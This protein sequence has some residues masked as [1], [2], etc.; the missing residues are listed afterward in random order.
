[1]RKFQYIVL[2]VAITTFVNCRPPLTFETYDNPLESSRF[3]A[4]NIFDG[5]LIAAGGYSGTHY[6]YGHKVW[7]SSDGVTWREVGTLPEE[8]V[9]AKLEVFDN[10]LWLIGGFEVY[11][12]DYASEMLKSADGI[13]WERE[14]FPEG[15]S[16]VLNSY[17][18]RDRLFITTHHDT[19][20]ETRLYAREEGGNW[21]RVTS[22]RTM[23][24]YTRTAELAGKLYGFTDG[25]L[26][27]DGSVAYRN[28]IYS[29]T[30]GINWRRE[31]TP[32]VYISPRSLYSAAVYRRKIWLVGG[33]DGRDTF[34]NDVWSFNELEGWKRY[35]PRSKPPFSGL[36]FHHSLAY[37]D[38]LWLFLGYERFLGSPKNYNLEN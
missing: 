7:R 14:A 1:M 10:T 12:V 2:G 18:F 21:E 19:L 31:P 37:G 26:N 35:T 36:R 15:A 20:R 11:D 24:I 25:K 3:A 9:D 16:R 17:V 28:E 8:R 13:T 29:T 5:D 38:K 30:D 33:W 23:G 4:F 22:Y 27:S 34:Y 32:T 6:P